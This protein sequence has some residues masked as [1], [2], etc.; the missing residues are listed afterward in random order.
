MRRS[1]PPTRP[2]CSPP[3]CRKSRRGRTVVIGAGKGAA[4][5]AQVFERLWDGPL[6][7][8]VVTRYGYG[9]R[10]ERIEVLEA[11]HPLPDENGL[12]AVAA[13]AGTR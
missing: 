9:A 5:M 10:C 3:T 12:T 1:P 11:S 13:V 4:Q 2:G 8:A 7:G 6:T